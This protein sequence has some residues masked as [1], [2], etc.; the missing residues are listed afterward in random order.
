[1]TTHSHSNPLYKLKLKAEKILQKMA[2]SPD[3]PAGHDTESILHDLRVHQ[4][5][6]EI[7]NEDLIQ[8]QQEAQSLKEQYFNLF[9]QAPVGYISVDHSGIIQK[10]N[11]H[12]C[13]M[14]NLEP[15]KF[16]RRPISQFITEADRDQFNKNFL[17][18]RNYGGSV[19]MNTHMLKSSNDVI[20]TEVVIK[21][22]KNLYQ[23]EKPQESILIVILDISDKVQAQTALLESKTRLKQ[24]IEDIPAMICRFNSD[25]FITYANQ[26]FGDYFRCEN[27]T[28]LG[29]N[30]FN[31][32]PEDK[33]NLFVR[34]F[35]ELKQ[36]DPVNT[37]EYSLKSGKK[38]IWFRW[39]IRAIFDDNGRSV[40]LQTV[41]QDITQLVQ[42]RN[43]REEKKRL[44]SLVELSGAICHELRQPLQI[45][46]GLTD[47]IAVQL[48]ED[49]DVDKDLQ[50]LKDQTVR[51]NQLLTRMNNIT[52]YK[53]K[54][55][56]NTSNI[57]DL[58]NASDRREVRRYMPK[59]KFFVQFSQQE[60]EIFPLIDISMGGLSFRSATPLD[61]TSETAAGIIIDESGQIL[62]HDLKCTVLQTAQK[63]TINAYKKKS[64]IEPEVYH[65]CFTD[66]D[67]LN[68]TGLKEF[69]QNH[70]LH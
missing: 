8:S 62:V 17:N 44:K 46:L 12:F 4:I 29:K 59:D 47:L 33:K 69:I 18:A 52:K 48:S 31:L 30:F 2:P 11:Q 40:K 15:S 51:I 43:E 10:T 36:T 39:T 50:R 41:G 61:F 58:E 38:Q 34:Q 37:I 49:K 24:I 22:L 66:R 13:S 60:K 27:N 32:V 9:D 23:S 42:S 5:E 53:T 1:M 63:N 55:Y 25:G 70:T 68:N 14:L 57:I 3:A 35:S 7:Q 56:T 20:D 19:V 28:C 6:L 45:L 65:V 16:Y 64:P 67:G 54:S 21:V 26:E